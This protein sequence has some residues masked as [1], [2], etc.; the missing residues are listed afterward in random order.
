MKKLFFITAI[1]S[2]FTIAAYAQKDAVQAVKDA[3]NPLAS[4]KSVS[5]H[6]IYAPALTEMDGTTNAMWLRFAK[7][8]GKLLMR[9]SLPINSVNMGDV[10]ESGLGDFT[11][12]GAYILSKPTSHKQFGVGPLLR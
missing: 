1:A 8:F 12:F 5:V 11:V 4:I 10:N 7:P 2:L 9:A 6:N 3:N